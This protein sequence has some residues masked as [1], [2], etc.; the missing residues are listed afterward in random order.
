MVVLQQA[1][2]SRKPCARMIA[3][4][5]CLRCFDPC[6]ATLLFFSINDHPAPSIPPIDDIFRAVK[7]PEQFHFYVLRSRDTSLRADRQHHLHPGVFMP[8]PAASRRKPSP[9]S[10]LPQTFLLSASTSLTSLSLSSSLSR[11][12]LAHDEP[13]PLYDT[14]CFNP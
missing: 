4:Y 7:S 13:F 5:G 14:G 12:A 10:L 6:Q 11:L 9:A 8:P 2:D 3:I 1:M